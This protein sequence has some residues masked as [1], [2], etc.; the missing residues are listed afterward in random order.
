VKLGNIGLAGLSLIGLG[1]ALT[2]CAPPWRGPP[3]YDSIFDQDRLIE[4]NITISDENWLKLI[5]DPKEYVEADLTV[6]G[7]LYPAVGLRLMGTKRKLKRNM[8]IRFNEFIADQRFFGVKR[9]NLRNNDDDP[10]Q[11][12]EALA[13]ELFERAK[14]PACLS[15]YVWVTKNGMDGS[16]YTLVE[17]V[18]KKFLERN[19]G[20]DWGNLYKIERGGDLVYQGDAITEYPFLFESRYE[21]KT[22]EIQSDYGDLINLMKTLALKD[23]AEFEESIQA[24]LDI[25]QVL[26]ALAV[27]TWL[28]NLDAY[29]GTVDN[30]FLYQAAGGHFKY[31]PWDLNLAFGN[32][33]GGSCHYT[34]DE[35][36]ALS[37]M[38]PT[39]DGPRPL[40]TSLLS[41]GAFR[42]IYENHLQEL[43]DGPL[44]PDAVLNE[45]ERMRQ[46]IKDRVVEDELT[47]F[48]SD[49]FDLS[50]SSDLPAGDN[51]VR[52]PGLEPFVLARD[53]AIREYLESSR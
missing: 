25:E 38:Q 23:Q 47:E 48:S 41:V 50:F 7:V 12:R 32:Y 11:V 8:R 21:K 26:R 13:L 24:I 45:I 40:V 52:I 31:S 4:F 43:I 14:L 42:Q 15:S 37:P 27:N 29:Q 5:V 10:T 46:L 22:N 35:L 19:F 34:T 36:L 18:D 3:D 39:C 2:A 6:D 51:P 33:H 30:L 17:Q 16:V 9:I 28:A 1:L 53:R 49:E 20:E 44:H